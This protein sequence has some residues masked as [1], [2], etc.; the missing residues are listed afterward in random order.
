MCQINNSYLKTPVVP[1]ML[2]RDVF[3]VIWTY[4][5][6]SL[7]EK[8]T[9]YSPIPKFIKM[10]AKYWIQVFIYTNIHT[11]LS[12]SPTKTRM[13]VVPVRQFDWTENCACTRRYTYFVYKQISSSVF[14]GLLDLTHHKRVNTLITLNQFST[15]R[16]RDF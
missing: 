13:W 6:L 16:T 14:C 15:G 9:L 2:L 10:I 5:V 3:V 4:F 7:Y 12:Y 1:Q 11:N 8:Q